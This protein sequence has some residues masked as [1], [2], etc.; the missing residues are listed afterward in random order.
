M[1]LAT[2]AERGPRAYEEGVRKVRSAYEVLEGEACLERVCELLGY[3]EEEMTNPGGE[4]LVLEVT[5]YSEKERE[6]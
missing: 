5:T 6:R 3:L 1:T 4:G 2:C